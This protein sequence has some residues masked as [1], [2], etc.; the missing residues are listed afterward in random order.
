M[1][2]S[3]IEPVVVLFFSADCIG[4]TQ[5]KHES[6][7]SAKSSIDN[8]APDIV[9]FYQNFRE[10]M[11]AKGIQFWKYNGDEILFFVTLKS[12]A[13]ARDYTIHFQEL[14]KEQNKQKT[15]IKVKGTAWTAGFPVDNVILQSK[16]SDSIDFIG[17]DIDLGF[18]IATLARKDRIAVSPDLASEIIPLVAVGE[19]MQWFYY[20]R[21]MLKGVPE[22]DGVPVAF[23]SG[24]D[25]SLLDEE[26]CLLKNR[27]DSNEL[28]SFLKNY[29]L[30]TKVC[31]KKILFQNIKEAQADKKYWNRYKKIAAPLAKLHP[32]YYSDI[33]EQC[34]AEKKKEGDCVL[35]NIK[36]APAQRAN[37]N[38]HKK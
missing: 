6:R 13:E 19:K 23:I 7:Y 22:S 3:P 5:L 18:R 29:L 21:K 10:K 4:S 28:C 26:D 16:D 8:W 15:K 32:D 24:G 20:G 38:K 11:N 17:P 36:L 34:S 25:S 1:K 37:K 31:T 2:I 12:W 14:V 35:K 27:V 9:Y 33:M 30:G